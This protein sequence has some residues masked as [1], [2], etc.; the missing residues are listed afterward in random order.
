MTIESQ[1]T[2][3]YALKR[4]VYEQYTASIGN[5]LGQLLAKESIGHLPLELRTKTIES[6]GEKLTRPE[7]LDKYTS[8]EDVTDLSG[9]RVITY[10]QED[11]E[12][13]VKIINKYFEVDKV[14]ST[15]KDEMLD[16]D[17]FGYKSIHFV[18][19][20][21]DS[22]LSLPD[23]EQF[24]GMTAEIQVRS[25][26]QHTWAA[27]DWKLR[28]GEELAIPNELKR[29]L[30]RISA[31]LEAADEDF[32]YLREKIEEIRGGYKKSIKSGNLDIEVNQDSIEL[33]LESSNAVKSLM[34]IAVDSG[35]SINPKPT[36]SRSPNYNLLDTLAMI[37]VS[38]VSDLDRLLVEFLRDA[39]Q[40]LRDIYNS[41]YTPD[42]PSKLAIDAG[43]LVRI[44]IIMSSVP[45]A[46]REIVLACPFGRE[47]QRSLLAIVEDGLPRLSAES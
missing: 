3:N 15:N 40:S 12:L 4:P 43:T 33:F 8:Y 1:L 13:V 39:E 19:K 32:S 17:R 44:A 18:V 16:V 24:K 46:A 47:L 5:V 6:F 26:V 27:I 36:N 10:F 34:R 30:F 20:Y 37:R 28:Y 35:Y 42:K 45:E 11:R 38:R 41:W 23:F 7:K 25:L 9:V 22:R 29:R 14:N 21:T 31:L 2:T